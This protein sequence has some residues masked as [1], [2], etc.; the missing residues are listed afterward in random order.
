MSA[1]RLTIA[2]SLMHWCISCVGLSAI[3][4]AGRRLIASMQ[5]TLIDRSHSR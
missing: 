1:R 2:D 5:S 4:V 3:M